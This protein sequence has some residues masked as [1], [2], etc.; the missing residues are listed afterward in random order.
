MSK[1]KIMGSMVGMPSP[2]PDWNETNPL[3]GSFIQNKPDFEG[4]RSDVNSLIMQD[5]PTIYSYLHSTMD[6]VD[7]LTAPPITTVPNTLEPNKAYNFG[8]CTELSLSFPE[9]ADDGD[10]IHIMF[11]CYE[12]PTNLIINTHNTT[13]IDLVPE[14]N[15]GYEIYAKFDG[16]TLYWI[17]KYSEHE[18]W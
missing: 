5:L 6:K 3:K 13:D 4:L 15:M 12:T 10:V 2:R 8:K 16:A 14:E 1:N 9:L 11:H 7:V 17:V 18:V